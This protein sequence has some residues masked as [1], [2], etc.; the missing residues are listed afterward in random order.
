M[1]KFKKIVLLFLGIL[2][3]FFGIVFLKGVKT[4]SVMSVADTDSMFSPKQD[5]RWDILI[6]GE[7]PL[8]GLTDSIMVLSFEKKTEKIAL[9]SVPRDLW[10]S[11]PGYGMHKI[12]ETYKRGKTND[13]NGGGL[14]LAKEVVSDVTGLEIDFA[15]IVDIYALKEVVDTM[16][17]IEVYGTQSFFADF[18]GYKANIRKGINY[19]NGSE[20]LAYIGSRK[21]GSDFGRMER[22][23][24]TLVAI[25][26]KAFSAGFLARPD[27][28][29]SIF[30]SLE[31]HIKTDL[32][33]SQIKDVAQMV[34]SLEIED[35]E[36]TVFNT[37]NYLYS[38]HSNGGAYILL[39][40]AGDFSE[41]QDECQNIFT[42]QE[43]SN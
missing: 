1:N 35:M 7:Q 31:R 3:V 29:W 2:V 33:P 24:K 28:I 30:S 39:P 36:Q 6:L 20:A 37:S 25:K 40:K 12:N 43:V 34:S 42:E 38:T 15:V 32:P 26:D 14:K 18:Y 19:L 8:G 17:G 27:K 16:D 9:F 10:V 21:I 4:V 23:Q 11:I 22:Q 41:I 13:K 5:E